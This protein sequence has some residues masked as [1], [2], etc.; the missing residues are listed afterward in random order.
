MLSNAH[1]ALYALSSSVQLQ[2][3]KNQTRLFFSSSDQ[4]V[5]KH[6]GV[7]SEIWNAQRAVGAA[8]IKQGCEEWRDKV[9]L[10]DKQFAAVMQNCHARCAVPGKRCKA[11][12]ANFVT[13]YLEETSQAHRILLEGSWG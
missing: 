7:C 13:Q 10:D 8:A 3:P 12:P 1:C 9:K 11:T 4:S 6:L 5:L 2:N